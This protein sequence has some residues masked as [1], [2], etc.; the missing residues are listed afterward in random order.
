MAGGRISPPTI[1]EDNNNVDCASSSLP[2]TAFTLTF[3][4]VNFQLTP[5][6]SDHAQNDASSN[7]SPQVVIPSMTSSEIKLNLSD[8]TG[9]LTVSLSSI[10]TPAPSPATTSISKEI[11]CL[12]RREGSQ[13]VEEEPPPT[14]PHNDVPSSTLFHSATTAAAENNVPVVSPKLRG[15]GQ[16]T[17]PFFRRKNTRRSTTKA[18]K[19]KER[20]SVGVEEGIEK[21]DKQSEPEVMVVSPPATKRRLPSSAA[22]KDQAQQNV[23]PESE[24]KLKKKKTRKTAQ[25]GD[26]GM[27]DMNEEVCDNAPPPI[28]G[29][30]SNAESQLSQVELSSATLMGDD[31]NMDT[32]P[33]AKD[34]NNASA[35]EEKINSTRR[36]A[37]QS[38]IVQEIVKNID[39]GAVSESDKKS[40]YGDDDDDD[41][42][43]EGNNDNTIME[44]DDCLS[45]EVK[46]AEE[47]D[48]EISNKL[49]SST[50]TSFFQ[51][52]RKSINSKTNNPP[53]PRWGQTMTL[54]DHSRM[55]IYGGQAPGAEN[56]DSFTT[57]SDIHVYDIAQN[58]WTKPVNCHGVPRTW[59]TATFLPERQLLISFGGESTNPKTGRVTTTDEVMVLDTDIMLWY[60]PSVTGSIPSGR[61]GHTA[62]L[63]PHTNELVVFGGVR[64]RKWLNSVSVLDTT[65]WKWTTPKIAGAAPRPRSYHS[66]TPIAL[67]STS[68]G[69]TDERRGSSGGR[70]NRLVIFGGNN[71]DTSFNT[72]H[73]LDAADGN[74]WRWFHPDVKGTPPCPRTGHCAT[75]LEDNKTILIY[76][77]WDPCGEDDDEESDEEI[78]QDSF[79]LDTETW[80][81]KSG[82][83]PRY[84]GG[85]SSKGAAPNGGPC[86]VGHSAVLAPGEQGAEVLVFGGRISGDDFASD[87]QTLTTPRNVVGLG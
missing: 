74:K 34:V 76:G 26:V 33:H 1:H 27:D 19:V 28:L 32:P 61:S 17:L 78:F 16:Q 45:A 57:L 38:P 6:E 62:S 84:A 80:T 30:L 60:P 65:R 25:D 54:I 15:K 68:G 11:T 64:N 51:P 46:E 22:K 43:E 37:P 14:P 58:K 55:I 7:A 48:T 56:D 63:L 69:Q 20:S 9:S 81:W 83:K 53:C 75:L 13:M 40:Q 85:S 4:G 8:F 70:V 39:N 42:S 41:V 10:N 79:L 72:V 36:K 5:K 52:A 29:Q 86:R 24:P 31:C 82:P 23:S 47:N 77:R 66:A 49:E 2:S 21:D 35:G 71:D 18:G 12:E 67:A 73:V 50:T 3:G 44:L 87:F 59:H